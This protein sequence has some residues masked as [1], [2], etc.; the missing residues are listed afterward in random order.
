MKFSS[1]R[2]L[3]SDFSASVSF[4]RDVMEL[5]MTFGDETAHYAYFDAGNVALELF[6]R[7]NNAAAFGEATPVPKPTGHHAIISFQ[8]DDVDATYADLVKRGATSFAPPHTPN[9][10][11]SRTRPPTSMRYRRSPTRCTT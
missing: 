3:V 6:S 11:R 5:S 1:I 7:D 9:S 8:V 10:V 4:W 2:L